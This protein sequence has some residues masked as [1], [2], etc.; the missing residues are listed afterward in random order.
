MQKRLT[1]VNCW[2]HIVKLMIQAVVLQGPPSGQKIL[3]PNVPE[4]LGIVLI[5][6]NSTFNVFFSHPDALKYG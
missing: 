5:K 2:H 6:T 3:L 4:L 1:S